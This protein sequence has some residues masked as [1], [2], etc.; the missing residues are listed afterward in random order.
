[1]CGLRHDARYKGRREN[2]FASVVMSARE[3]AFFAEPKR[4]NML[5]AAAPDFW[6]R[7]TPD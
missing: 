2:R 5:P 3:S 4:R 1:M 7:T 6:T